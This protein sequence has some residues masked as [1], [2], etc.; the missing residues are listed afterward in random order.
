M[1]DISNPAVDFDVENYCARFAAVYTGAISDVLDE[2][3]YRDQSLPSN[4][5]GLT[6]EHRVAGV[7]M[8]VEGEPTKSLDPEEIF[9]PILKMLGDLKPGD[10]IVTQ[11]HDHVSAHIGELS[12]EAAKYRGARGAVIDG[13]ARDIDYILK[14]R[15]PVF[16]RYRTPR[17]VMGR[18]KLTRYGH[19][20]QIGKVAISRG[21]FI[22]GD[23][24]GVLVIPR[25]ITRQVLEKTEEVVHTENLVRKAILQGV[26]PADAYRKYGRF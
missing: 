1:G 12:S 20:V 6:I 18:W 10:V 4:I 3:G 13:G 5:Q 25:A 2:M 11:P 16:C 15:F 23:R 17:D 14:L 26:H 22:V 7:A 8:P 24:D 21:D 19:T 9:I